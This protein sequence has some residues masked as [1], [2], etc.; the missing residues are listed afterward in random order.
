MR[1]FFNSCISFDALLCVQI[2]KLSGRKFVDHI[3]YIISRLGDGWLYAVFTGIYIALRTRAALS[4][5]PA[6]LTAF[7]LESVVYM[8]IKKNVKRIRPLNTLEAVTSLIIPP[9]EFSFP[10]GHTAAAAVFTVLCGTVYPH[11]LPALILYT[12]AIGFSRV[13]NGVHYP[14]D[15]FAGAALGLIS[16]K[17][18]LLIF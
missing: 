16:A 5:L 13:Y 15:V 6:I 7:A 3:F 17:I 18:S 12:T 1:R 11:A 8:L 4:M 10:S 14:G 9:D 2:Y